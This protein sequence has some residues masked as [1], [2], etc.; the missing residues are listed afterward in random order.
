MFRAGLRSILIGSMVLGAA[1]AQPGRGGP[2]A[3]WQRKAQPLLR[4]GKLQEA[5]VIYQEELKNSPDSPAANNAAGI[6]FDLMGKGAEARRR[7]QKAIDT[8]PNS[9]AKANADRA[10]AMSYAFEGDCGN[11]VKYEQE[12][13]DYWKTRESAEP[14]NAFYQE[15]EMANEAARVC[16]DSGDFATAEKRYRAGREAGLREPGIAPG[17]K[18]LWEFRTEHALA[19][20]AARRGNKEEAEKHVAAAKSALSQIEAA[21]AQLYR[22]QSAFLPYL[23]GYIAYYTGDYQTA[24]ADLQKA[25]TNDA[26]IQCLLGMTYEKLGQKDQALEQYRKGSLVTAHNPPAA[27]AKRFTRRYVR[28]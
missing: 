11:T 15:G 19:R 10:M 26:F 23:T 6:V 24:L 16:I 3:E 18:A 22:Q 27:F 20:L 21:D 8:A 1:I 5:L 12:V 4:E 2:Q 28:G 13:F 9:Q 14:G 25:N 7:F 17:R